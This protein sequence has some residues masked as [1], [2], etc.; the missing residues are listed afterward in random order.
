MFWSLAETPEEGGST[1]AQ[2]FEGLGSELAGHMC[3]GRTSEQK[4]PMAE[5]SPQGEQRSEQGERPTLS[6]PSPSFLI[7]CEEAWSCDSVNQNHSQGTLGTPVR[8]QCH[9]DSV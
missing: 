8:G 4:E 7:S 6:Q 3:L 5:E 2:S 1:R 9:S